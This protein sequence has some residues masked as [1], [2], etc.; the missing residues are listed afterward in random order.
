MCGYRVGVCGYRVGV[1]LAI[2]YAYVLAKAI[3]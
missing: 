1:C 3:G 2:E